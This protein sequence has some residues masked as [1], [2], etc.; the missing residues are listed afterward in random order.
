MSATDRVPGLRVLY[1]TEIFL[2]YTGGTQVLGASLLAGLRTRDY[3]Y[4]EYD[5]GERE[6]YDVRR[7]PYQLENISDTADPALLAALSAQL[8]MLRTCTGV[9]CRTADSLPVAAAP[10]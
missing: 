1:W 2:P 3:T 4:I 7:D 6:L 8:A 5:T 9:T 10:R